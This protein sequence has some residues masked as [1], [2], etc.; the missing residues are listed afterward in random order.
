M[1]NN[2]QK[3]RK[4]IEGHILAIREYVKNAGLDAS[5]ISMASFEDEKR[6]WAHLMTHDK[7]FILC[8]NFEEEKL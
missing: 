2:L 7:N 1:G 3:L 6:N 4:K 5:Y 8:Y